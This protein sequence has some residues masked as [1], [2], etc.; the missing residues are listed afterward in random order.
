MWGDPLP[1]VAA[2][3]SA[4]PGASS[5]GPYSRPVTTSVRPFGT[6]PSSVSL[7]ALVGA[8]VWR[9]WLCVDAGDLYWVESDPA[10]AGRAFVRRH[11]LGRGVP[12]WVGDLAVR[13]RVHSFGARPIAARDGHVVVVGDDDQRLYRLTPGRVPEALG[14]PPR[15]ARSVRH[16][17][18]DLDGHGQLVALRERDTPTGA[19]DE[20]VL[21]DLAS[22]TETTVLAGHDFFGAPVLSPDGR[23]VAAVAWDHPDMPWDSTVLLEA[24]LADGTS[25]VVLG[26]TGESVTQPR[27][28]PDGTL[29][30]ITDPTGWWNLHRR[31]GEDW[32]DVTPSEAEFAPPPWLAG[33]TSYAPA[34]D[35][36]ILLTWTRDGLDHVGVLARD[37]GLTALE[38][39]WTAVGGVAASEGAAAL[40]GGGALFSDRV[41]RLEPRSRRPGPVV[42]SSEPGLEPDDVARPEVLAVDAPAGPV[43][44]LYYPPTS[45]AFTGPSGEAPP[46]VLHTHSGPTRRALA[47]FDLEV[48]FFTTR[49]YAYLDVNY[50]GSAGFGRAY[51]ERLRGRWG[52]V[53]VDD[54]AACVRACAER[55]L[56]DPARVVSIGASASGVTTLGLARRGV[57]AA[58][59]L[60]Y[61]VTDLRGLA[62]A[63]A[64]FEAHY[65]DGLVGPLPEAEHLYAERSA[66]G[67]VDE[68]S[69]P[70]LLFHGT[71]DEVV[72]LGQSLALA[73]ALEARGVPHGLVV[74]EGEGHGFTD[75]ATWR[76]EAAIEESFFA[77]VLGLAPFDEALGVEIR[78]AGAL[79]PLV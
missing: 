67:F 2:S 58:A 18:P 55:G 4:A 6:W 33:E 26:G 16:G 50:G 62:V 76:R 8:G 9:R 61:P 64:R 14:A 79:A 46:A 69:T 57:L 12:E 68:L 56:L 27:Y 37:G 10:R 60:R 49:G 22:G 74:V 36:S 24:D 47:Q 11:R 77:R 7:D 29:Y 21:I 17:A 23:R 3:G 40:V 42:A 43:H 28:G 30:A 1:G 41:Q 19:I 31:D 63:P 35:G 38:G 72:P 39:P 25:R 44:A 20:I 78:H 32:V 53:D 45:A 15:V 54:A 51:R 52:V 70:L 71:E 73:A 59:S 5:G 13:S 65:L 34:A 75:P 48:Q 66:V